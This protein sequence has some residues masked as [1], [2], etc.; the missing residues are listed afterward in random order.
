MT[1]HKYGWIKDRGDPRDFLFTKVH[2]PA[3]PLPV[4][5]KISLRAKMPPVWNQGELG[6]CSAHGVLACFNFVHKG[7]PWSRLELYYEE[8]VLEGTVDQDSG[9]MIRDG[10]KILANIGVG[11]ESEWPYDVTKFKDAPPEKLLAESSANKI[12]T[13]SRLLN[14]QDMIQCLLSGYP[15]VFGMQLYESFETPQVAQ[16]GI[17]R[18]PSSVEQCLGGHCMSIVGYNSNVYGS[19]F[20]EVRNSWDTTWGDNGY[21]WIEDSYMTNSDIGASDLWTIRK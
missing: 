2:A 4:P 8:R 14:K 5:P 6:S 18:L 7:G 19:F 10:I 1:N 3:A 13:Y 16:S 20:W 9:A 17:I 15:I 21:C 11:L 12:I